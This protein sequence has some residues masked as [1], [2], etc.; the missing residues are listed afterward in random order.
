MLV[1]EAWNMDLFFRLL[2]AVLNI[3]QNEHAPNKHLETEAGS[4]QTANWLLLEPTT[5]ASI[6]RAS[7]LAD[8]YRMW[9]Y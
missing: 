9:T 1:P 4:S 3:N 2:Q 8:M 6:T 7:R 5:Q